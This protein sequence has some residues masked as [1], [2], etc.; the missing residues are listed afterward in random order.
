MLH[1]A[2]LNTLRFKASLFS[3]LLVVAMCLFFILLGNG[4]L[5]SL[6]A[7][8]RE[9]RH[10]NFQ[11]QVSGLLEESRQEL[12]RLAELIALSPRGRISSRD[13]LRKTMS[14]QWELLQHS[15]DLHSLKVYDG[16]SEPVLSWGS[17]HNAL[18]PDQVKQVLLRGQPL[19]LVHCE[20][21]CVQSLSLPM[22][23]RGGDYVL[24]VDRPL[25]NQ[26]RRFR[27]MTGSDIAILSAE[28]EEVPA[29]AGSKYLASWRREVLSLTS[30]ERVL[31]LLTGV[32]G[33]VPA[34]SELHRLRVFELDDREFDIR[35]MRVDV[36]E[37][38]AQFVFIEDVS[39]QVEH[40]DQSVKLLFLFSVLGA[41]IFSAAVA[42]TLWRPIVRLRRLAQALPLLT[43][44]RFDEARRLI[45]PV[46]KSIDKFDELDVLDNTGLTMCDQLEDMNDM[47]T[48]KTAQLE[49]IAMHD[50]LTGLDN[51]YSLLEQLEFHLQLSEHQPEPVPER[52][53]VFFIDLDDFKLVNDTLGHQGG[54]ELL[55]VIARRLLSVMRCGDIVA[56]LG[57]DEFCVLVRGLKEPEAYRV[58]AEKLLNTVAQ[59]VK[60]EDSEVTVTMSVGV[61][62]VDEKGETLEAILQ[63][64]DIAMYHAKRHGKNK[65]QLYTPDLRAE[66]DE[67]RVSPNHSLPGKGPVT[68]LELVTT[69]PR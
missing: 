41:L 1:L 69:K 5:Q 29:E 47:V 38:G 53:Y 65:Y 28:R 23:A 21:T 31:P 54:D 2:N 30:Q 34:V 8:S 55:C 19:D 26:L 7:K 66:A 45:R 59:P 57:G 48:R 10:L 63:K 18:T 25:T 14:R 4:S 15:W 12:S 39:E 50:S 40:I 33:E 61:V 37:Q 13:E 27:E 67:V 52:G 3:L 56:R 43:N 51:R 6:L 62:A 68:P 9:H 16:G 32:A 42:G 35:T 17:P 24:Q 22:R 44:G 49:Q 11:F 58:L 64:A 46:F 36:D 60:I 20:H